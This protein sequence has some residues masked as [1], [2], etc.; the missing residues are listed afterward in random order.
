MKSFLK[1]F[2]TEDIFLFLSVCFILT[3]ALIHPFVNG[4]F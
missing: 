2:E 3:F 4:P 1:K